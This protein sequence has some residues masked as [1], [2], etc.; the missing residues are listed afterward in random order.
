MKITRHSTRAM[1]HRYKALDE[2]DL[3]KLIKQMKAVV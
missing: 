3:R 2:E 1:F